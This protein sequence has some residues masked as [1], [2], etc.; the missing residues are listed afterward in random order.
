ME[1]LIN[2][3]AVSVTDAAM[4]RMPSPSTSLLS[5]RSSVGL[6][7]PIY[8]LSAPHL[9]YTSC[10]SLRT[11]I[12]RHRSNM[13]LGQAHVES[14]VPAVAPPHLATCHSLKSDE[15]LHG[16]PHQ[17]PEGSRGKKEERPGMAAPA[18]R[19]IRVAGKRPSHVTAAGSAHSPSLGFIVVQTGV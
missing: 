5:V 19:R 12:V 17:L 9:V 8:P 16:I 4:R 6:S 18:R 7:H 11:G 2:E 15:T 14:S 1:G 13:T 3:G 10:P